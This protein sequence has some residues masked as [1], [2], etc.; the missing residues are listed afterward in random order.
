V[1][2]GDLLILKRSQNFLNFVEMEKGVGTF[3][4]FFKKKKEKIKNY[5][6]KLG[7]NLYL[8]VSFTLSI[9]K[10]GRFYFRAERGNDQMGVTLLKFY[11]H[12]K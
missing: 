7:V 6:Q 10:I 5:A 2:E 11:F 1:H 3:F 12:F 9:I 4:F 8:S